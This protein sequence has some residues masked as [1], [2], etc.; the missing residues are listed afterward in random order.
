M[1]IGGSR[2]IGAAI[3]RR[4]AKGGALVTITYAASP[5]KAKQVVGSIEQEGGKAIAIQA[6]SGDSAAVKQT[7]QKTVDTFGRID[8]L[9]KNAGVATFQKPPLKNR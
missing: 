6:E 5:E 9:V 8:I 3:A 1:A 4:L 2:S 7:V